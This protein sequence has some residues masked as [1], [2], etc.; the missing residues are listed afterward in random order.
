[1]AHARVLLVPIL[2]LLTVAVVGCDK[3]ATTS[4]TPPTSAVAPTQTVP[5]V[6]ARGGRGMRWGLIPQWSKDASGKYAT[7]NARI[8]SAGQAVRVGRW[9]AIDAEHLLCSF[10][11]AGVVQEQKLGSRPRM[12]IVNSSCF[13]AENVDLS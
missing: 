9:L 1:M 6:T 12:L 13:A 11:E 8:E 5:V 4:D 10:Q 3:K 7:F 2:V